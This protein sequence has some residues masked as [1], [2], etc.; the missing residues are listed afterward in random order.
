MSEA[1]SLA[2]MVKFLWLP[3]LGVFAWF[4]KNTYSALV[5][6]V[7]A[8]KEQLERS[9]DKVDGLTTSMAVV[10][11]TKVEMSEFDSRMQQMSNHIDSKID[12]ISEKQDEMLRL[13]V[14]RNNQS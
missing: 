3:V 5:E 8:L 4:F 14:D 7:K 1:F 10:K 9:S 6:R 2:D 12:K 13:M 11:A